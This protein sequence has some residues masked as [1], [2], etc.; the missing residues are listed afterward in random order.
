MLELYF[1][2]INTIKK[3]IFLI[4][5]VFLVPFYFSK[6]D[7]VT[8]KGSLYILFA[9]LF[10]L[11]HSF[12]FSFDKFFSITESVHALLVVFTLFMTTQLFKPRAIF[13]YYT[14]LIFVITAIL[15]ISS[16]LILL[17]NNASKY[18]VDGNFRGILQNSNTLAFYLSV[19]IAPYYFNRLFATTL[20]KKKSFLFYFII[21]NLG[22]FIIL[23]RSR[24]SIVI[25]ILLCVFLGIKKLK[26]TA[27]SLIV[28][29]IF[30]IALSIF[31]FTNM[32]LVESYVVKNEGAAVFSTRSLLFDARL[33]AISQK[34][35]F[36]WGYQVNEFS[37]VDEFNIFNKSEKGNTLLALLEEFGLVFGSL[38]IFF[39]GS[40]FYGAIRAL[41]S[42]PEYFFIAITLFS[43][44]LHLLLETWLFNFNGFLSVLIWLILM[45]AYRLKQIGIDNYG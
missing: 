7:K 40:I 13:N 37:Y 17:F 26:L 34:P 31:L 42:F 39:L 8:P 35:L 4:V 6:G 36:G 28:S 14:K 45:T 41:K 24:T 38:L 1:H 32:S 44:T 2:D 10:I 27:G 43:S 12:I 18:Y 30:L 21:S 19:F 22:F 9:F 5:F 33:E 11:V 16:I 23:T 15:L 25:F 20:S 29:F 3:I